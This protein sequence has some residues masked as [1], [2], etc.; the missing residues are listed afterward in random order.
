[1]VEGLVSARPSMTGGEA[2][3]QGRRPLQFCCELWLLRSRVVCFQRNKIGSSAAAARRFR[4]RL[5]RP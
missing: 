5:Q 4:L 1:M 3:V 2:A